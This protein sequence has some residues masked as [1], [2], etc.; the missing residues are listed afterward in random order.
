MMRKQYMDAGEGGGYSKAS[1]AIENS[2]K[3][4]ED[5]DEDED[6]E[7]KKKKK[8]MASRIAG[9]IAGGLKGYAQTQM[10]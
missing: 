1:R 2:T 6:E 7:K 3:S 8:S 9:A 5:E 4:D 10:R